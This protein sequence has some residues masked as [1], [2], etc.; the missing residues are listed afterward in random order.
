MLAA[1]SHSLNLAAS[2]I[3]LH[4]VILWLLV[5]FRW[6]S[7]CL[8]GLFLSY[9]ELILRYVSFSHLL[10]AVARDCRGIRETF[11]VGLGQRILVNTTFLL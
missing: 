6:A 11:I 1:F 10:L 9:F 7:L 2:Y 5:L 8:L 3:E 4:L